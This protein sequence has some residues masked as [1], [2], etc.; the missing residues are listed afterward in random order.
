MKLICRY[1]FKVIKKNLKYYSK[2]IELPP[3]SLQ[4]WGLGCQNEGMILEISGFWHPNVSI[5][6][7]SDLWLTGRCN[8]APKV[9]LTDC[10]LHCLCG[11]E[12]KKGKKSEWLEAKHPVNALW[13]LVNSKDWTLF[14]IVLKVLFRSW[15]GSF[16]CTGMQFPGTVSWSCLWAMTSGELPSLAKPC[17]RNIPSFWGGRWSVPNPTAAVKRFWAQHKRL[18]NNNKSVHTEQPR[19]LRK[20]LI[21]SW[22]AEKA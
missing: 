8:A 11:G 17:C 19:L 15:T 6:V 9:S 18:C 14:H 20:W 12:R 2:N 22:V 5:S 13:T 1:N 4:I 7:R 10:K 3:R 16:S 21:D